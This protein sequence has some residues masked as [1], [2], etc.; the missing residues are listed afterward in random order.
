MTRPRQTIG[1]L[2][3]GHRPARILAIMSVALVLLAWAV[4]GAQIWERR[5]Q[6]FDDEKRT[7]SLLSL[8]LASQ[9]DRDLQTIDLVLRDAQK[10]LQSPEGKKYWTAQAAHELF[11]SLCSRLAAGVRRRGDR[12]EWGSFWPAAPALSPR[13]SM[14]RIGPISRNSCTIPRIIFISVSLSLV[15]STGAG[16]FC[17]RALAQPGWLSRHLRCNDRTESF[18]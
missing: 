1:N 11:R 17:W 3:A 4:N 15:G 16:R 14:S 8:S 9:M 6:A 7:L 12:Q 13:K 5:Q 10:V 18:Q 2:L